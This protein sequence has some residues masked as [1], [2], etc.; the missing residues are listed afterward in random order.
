[1]DVGTV[2]DRVGMAEFRQE[3]RVIERDA[4]DQVT[5]QRTAHLHRGRTVGLGQYGVA[6]AQLIECAEDIGTKLNAGA[7]LLELRCL[8][9][10][11]HRKTLARERT[12]GGKAT[13]AAAG[14]QERL[15]VCHMRSG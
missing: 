12:G 11:A 15:V 13:D 14:D 7:D 5:G 1:M 9:E 3:A 8:L 2:G 6:Q 10:N 4:R